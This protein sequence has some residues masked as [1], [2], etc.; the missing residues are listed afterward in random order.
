MSPVRLTRSAGYLA[1]VSHQ[2]GLI[3]AGGRDFRISRGEPWQYYSALSL[4]TNN[5]WT[6]LGDL[7]EPL[8][9]LCLVTTRLGGRTRLWAIGGSHVP[10]R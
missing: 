3:L 4:L 8:A 2:Q 1:S 10:Q 6:S 9:D 5:G 7:P